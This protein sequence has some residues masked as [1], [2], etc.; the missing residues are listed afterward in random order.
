MWLPRCAM[1][2]NP[3]LPSA[4]RT[5]RADRTGSLG[6]MAD[7]ERGDER[8][9]PDR[10]GVLV[11][12]VELDGFAQVGERLLHRLAL[13]GHVELRRPGRVGPSL[14]ADDGRQHHVVHAWG[15]GHMG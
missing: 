9:L 15:S 8:R 12:Q 13:A 7:F 2:T 3:A 4:R 5:S 6:A 1:G 11:L 14:L 10:G